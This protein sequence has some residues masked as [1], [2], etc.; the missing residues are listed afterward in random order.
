MAGRVRVERDGA[1]GFVVF[2][3]EARRNAI[4][5]EMWRQIPAVVRELDDDP[6]VRV[7]ILRGAGELAF[8]AGADISEFEAA[9]TGENVADYDT[10]NSAAFQALAGLHKPLI[11]MI[12]GFCVGGGVAIALN[13]DLRYA[14]DDA[15][16]AV[17]AARLGLAYP[18]SGLETLARLVG[19]SRAKEILF[20][21]RRFSA[22]E[23]LGLGLLNAVFPKAELEARVRQTAALI[24]DNAPLTLRA[25]KLALREYERPEAQ[26]N[27]AAIDGAVEA[28]FASADYKEGVA[29]F[30]EKRAPRFKGE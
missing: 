26:R 16:L 11:A 3:H 10:A 15:R 18:L 20:T 4:T 6:T 14:A 1:L 8:V 22:Q 25:A 29:A 23:A 19:S 30:L 27:H 2:D 17:P 12:H 13:A 9:R 24:A 21:A 28:C 5:L 7:V